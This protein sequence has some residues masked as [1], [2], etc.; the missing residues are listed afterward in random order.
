MLRTAPRHRLAAVVLTN[1]ESGGRLID[2][3]L[4]PWFADLADVAPSA[5][6]LTP[7]ADARV[8]DPRP[9]VGRYESRQGQFTVAQGDD[10]QLWLTHT[11][12]HE[13]L[14]F[15]ER[16]GVT[17]D[18]KRYELRPVGDGIFTTIEAGHAGEE[19]QAI[20]FLGRDSHD[21]ARFLFSGG[22]ASPRVD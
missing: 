1:A 6:F 19:A 9:Y 18:V 15:A 7:T 21:R 12:Q 20:E 16:A 22:R 13:T 3:L 14:E 4:E 17:V 2:D 10:D 5:K 11:P 8:A